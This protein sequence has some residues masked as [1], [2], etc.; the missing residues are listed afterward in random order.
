MIRSRGGTTQGDPLAMAMYEIALLP[1]VKLLE[2]TDVVQKWY[3]DD[4]NAVGK[5]KDLHRLHDALTERGPAFGYHITKC[6]NI[7]RKSHLGNAK[8]IFKNKDVDI[9]EGHRV[10]GSL[11]GSVS[12]CHDLKTKVV[13]EQAKTI[14]EL[15]QHAKTAP[16]NVYQAYT[17]GMQ[18]KLSFL[19][20]INSRHG[21]VPERARETNQRGLNITLPEDNKNVQKTT[22]MV[23]IPR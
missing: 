22:K 19:T 2:N 6:H 9:L 5:L 4:G 18:T 8:E 1:L 15:A 23:Q 16:R 3:A 7:A 13:S 12:A 10:L 17:K 11:I 21:R 14:S 20:L